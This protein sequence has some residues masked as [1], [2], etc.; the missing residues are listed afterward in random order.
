MLKNRFTKVII[1]FSKLFKNE[2]TELATRLKNQ[3]NEFLQGYRSDTFPNGILAVAQLSQVQVQ[4]P[5]VIVHLQVPFPCATELQIIE[6]Q[7]TEKLSLPVIIK[8][9]LQV[10]AIK[11]H[12]IS[13]VSN[14]IA[15]AS[16]KGGVGKSTT[17]V[18]LAYGLMAEGA[19]VGILDADIYGP[20]IPTLLAL[21]NQKPTSE[22][23][24]MLTPM[25]SHNLQAMSIGFL[26]DDND[27]TVWR[28]PMASRAFAQLLNETLWQDLDYLIVDMPPGTGDV[29]LTL[30]QKVPVAGA[31]I[32]TT[33]QDLA[34]ADAI[35]GIAMFNK[36]SVPI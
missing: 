26:V 24:K 21:Q 13:G 5:N 7:L 19:R 14:I 3:L 30:A 31:L 28:G 1:M 23:G 17:A 16:G 32:I 18:N 36:V 10:K 27:A 8:A 9:D 29:Q 15:V 2:N 20:S 33:P 25:F 35:K 11:K 12:A 22:D 4:E 6:L 34:L